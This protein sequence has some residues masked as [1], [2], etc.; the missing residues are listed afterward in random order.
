MPARVTIQDDRLV[1]ANHVC[2]ASGTRVAVA[3]TDLARIVM[4][5]PATATIAGDSGDL[6]AEVRGVVLCG[7]RLWT[8]N[9][10]GV[11]LGL[12]TADSPVLVES[13]DLGATTPTWVTAY[14]SVV[15][16]PAGEAGIATVNPATGAI[17]DQHDDVLTKVVFAIA[18]SAGYVYAFD[19]VGRGAVLTVSSAGILRVVTRF[20]AINVVGP[21]SGFID[22]ADLVVAC[23]R[24]SA[25]IVFDLVD[26]AE[27]A[28]STTTRY[29]GYTLRGVLDDDDRSPLTDEPY[30]A[31]GLAEWWP[32]A[33]GVVL[34]SGYPFLVHAATGRATMFPT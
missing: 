2:I 31:L 8:M 12:T 18:S 16:A 13:T 9:A 4:V 22:G 10:A 17:Y 7:S 25:V 6:G 1:G 32:I 23:E 24:R 30:A 27:P 19:G 29:A 14:A 33:H 21:V 26:P 28:L 15:I 34:A 11:L 5:A 20:T 3:C